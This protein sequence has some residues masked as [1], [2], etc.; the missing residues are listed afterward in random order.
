MKDQASI[1]AM[2]TVGA[3]C[4][5]LLGVVGYAMNL[6][7]IL[8]GCCAVINGTLVLRIIGV[9]MGPLGALMGYV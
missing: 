7:K 9:F 1:D 5:V 3:I 8:D 4:L 6:W 2:V